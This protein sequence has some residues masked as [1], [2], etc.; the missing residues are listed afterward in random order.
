M[1]FFVDTTHH[2]FKPG[3]HVRHALPGVLLL[4]MLLFTGVLQAQEKPLTTPLDSQDPIKITSDTL[5]A[6]NRNQTLFFKGNVKVV[7]GSTV[8]TSERLKVWYKNG[9]GGH[10]DLMT[11]RFL[12]DQIGV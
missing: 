7:Q 12:L 9:G 10:L 11:T 8:I 2:F 1:G 4:A 6:D 3:G 5:E